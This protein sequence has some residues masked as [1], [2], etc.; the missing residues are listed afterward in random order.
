MDERLVAIKAE[1]IECDE[2]WG[3]VG[4]KQKRVTRLD[5]HREVGG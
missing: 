4:K 5:N 1:E 3:Y 2:L